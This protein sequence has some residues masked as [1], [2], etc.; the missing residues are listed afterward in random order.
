MAVWQREGASVSALFTLPA[1][2]PQVTDLPPMSAGAPPRKALVLGY[3][4]H[5]SRYAFVVDGASPFLPG[6]D[7]ERFPAQGRQPA[8]PPVLL[9]FQD[10]KTFT[11]Q[12]KQ[13][14]TVAFANS[15]Q[16]QYQDDLLIVFLRGADRRLLDW[17]KLNIFKEAPDAKKLLDPK[18]PEQESTAL[19]TWTIEEGGAGI[20]AKIFCP[21]NP[22]PHG[23]NVKCKDDPSWTLRWQIGA[24]DDKLKIDRKRI[25][26]KGKGCEEE[27]YD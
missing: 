6:I 12:G 18:R 19:C 17:K 5:R 10:T 26:F 21:R 15:G 4:Q 22:D 14:V 24:K 11:I 16:Q 23:N 7:V 1:G 20:V 8:T 27:Y 9:S 2:F 13:Q 25:A 3:L